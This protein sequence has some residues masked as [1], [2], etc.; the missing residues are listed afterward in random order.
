MKPFTVFFG[1]ACMVA[2]FTPWVHSQDSVLLTEFMAVN[3]TS[4]QDNDGDYSDWIEIYNGGPGPVSLEGYRLTDDPADFGKWRFPA[5]NLVSHGY[6]LVFASGKDRRLPGQALH[7]NFKLDRNGEY[8]ALLKPDGVT[9]LTEYSPTF[10]PQQPNTC[11]G[12]AVETLASNLLVAPE[13]AARLFIPTN[14]DLDS[15]WIQTGFDESAWLPVTTA[16]K[17]DT[18]LTPTFDPLPGTDIQALMLSKS[19]T[20]YL[21]IPFERGDLSTLNDLQLTLRYD[22]GVVAYLNGAEVARRNSPAVPTWNSV[23]TIA[24]P[25]PA[26]LLP[27]FINLNSKLSS[28]KPGRNVLALQGLNKTKTD[29]DF[30]LFPELT[31]SRRQVLTSVT[32]FFSV[33]TPAAA[34]SPGLPGEAG[35]PRLSVESGVYTNTLRLSLSV[36]SATSVIRYTLDR[37]EPTLT[38]PLYSQ[39]IEITNSILLKARAFDPGLLPSPITVGTY[40]ILLPDLLNFTSDLPIVLVDN[41]GGKLVPEAPQ[42]AAIAIYEPVLGRSSILNAPDTFTRATLKDRGS[43]TAGQPK[44]NLAV[45]TIEDETRARDIAPFGMPQ[46]SDWILYAPLEWDRALF[47]NPFIYQLSNEMGRY[48]PR[49]RMVEVY[50]NGSGAV[51]K[52][53]YNGVYVWMEKVKQGPNRVDIAALEPND[54]KA[55]EVTGGYIFKIDRPDPADVGFS[56]G[57]QELK[58]VYPKEQDLKQT[59]RAPQ[60]AYLKSYLNSFA[61]ALPTTSFPGKPGNYAQYLDVDATIDFHILNLLS[62]NVDALVLST[63]LHKERN[64]PFTFGPVWDF[65]RSMGSYDGRDDDPLSWNSTVPDLFATTWFGR[66]FYD[67]DFFQRWVDRWQEL[68]RAQ[69]SDKHML[70]LIASFESELTEAQAR[71]FA[72]WSGFP[73]AGGHAGEVNIMRQW[74]LAR[75]AWVDKNFVPMPTLARPSGRISAGTE[76]EIVA[77][78]GTIFYTLD[79]TDPRLSGGKTNPNAV[80]YSGPIRLTQNSR[81]VARAKFNSLSWKNP[82]PAARLTNEW[83][84]AASATYVVSTPPIVVT[85]IMYHP[86]PPPP[87]SPYAVDDFEFVELKNIGDQPY[88][89]AG[90][91]FTDGI[92][93]TFTAASG[94]RL[95]AGQSMVLAKNV[96]AFRSRYGIQAKVAGPFLG[97]LSDA[98]ERL[99]LVGPYHEPILD[100]HYDNDW[101]MLTEGFGFSLTIVNGHAPL[102]SWSRPSSWRGSSQAG[103]SPGT[104]DPPTHL[105]H[106]R[107]NEVVALTDSV[108]GD[109]IELHNPTEA[110]VNLEGWYLTDDAKLPFKF[111]IP[112]GSILPAK[113]YLVFTEKQFGLGAKGFLLS[114]RG[115]D[116]WL[117]AADLAGHLLG[118]VHGFAF[119]ASDANTSFGRHVTTAGEEFFVAQSTPTMGR[120]NAGPKVGPVVIRELMYH[121]PD[122]FVN[123]AFWNNRADEYIELQNIT[124]NEVSLFDA[125]SGEPWGLRGSVHFD[126]GAPIHLPANEALILVGFDPGTRPAQ[127]TDFRSRFNLPESVRVLGPFSGNLE[128]SAGEVRLAKPGPT[129]PLTGE[130]S[131]VV[132]DQVDYKDQSPWPSAADGGGASLRRI[133]KASFGNDAANWF[134]A[135]PSPGT[136]RA[137]GVPPVISQPPQSK[138]ITRGHPAILSGQAEGMGP[139]VYQWRRDDSPVPG[140]TNTILTLDAVEDSDAGAYTLVV[141]NRNGSAESTPAFL[142]VLQPATI[143]VHPESKNLRPGTNATLL[144]VAIGI[145]KLSYQWTLNARPIL[146]ATGNVLNLIDAKLSDAGIYRVKVTDSIGSTVSDA[147]TINVLIRPTFLSQPSSL[148]ALLGDTVELGVEVDGLKPSGYRWRRNNQII[149]PAINSTATNRILRVSNVQF[150]SAGTYAV[151][152]TNLATG[153]SGT[154]SATAELIV[155]SDFDRDRLG[156]AWEAQF[157]YSTNNPF[158]AGFD[159]DGD[160]RDNLAEFL[161]GTDPKDKESY[162]RIESIQMTGQGPAVG[163]TARTN[164]GYTVQFREGVARGRWQ[165][166]SQVPA[167]TADRPVIVLDRFPQTAARLYRIATPQILG[168]LGTG[169]VILSSPASQTVVEGNSVHLEVIAIGEGELSYQWTKDHHDLP[170]ETRATLRMDRVSKTAAGSYIVR[171]RDANGTV[172]SEPALLV[173]LEKPVIP[174][175]P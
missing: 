150:A 132:V 143:V 10:P 57:G 173:I 8:L 61:A 20:A 65:D 148:V 11:F 105:P 96:E 66:L 28:I 3:E 6:L 163:F 17:F 141:I 42:Q 175:H 46:E 24:R 89:L 30:L 48:A 22:D 130:V 68:R 117:F 32:R 119:G 90:A 12:L 124:G 114:S 159:D 31:A 113:G 52:V 75:T 109:S 100:F 85:E 69:L 29:P 160:G 99:V 27:E 112:T 103:G 120:S 151:Q 33:P 127:L 146:G 97:S 9:V 154:N 56:A 168:Q 129:D 47:R 171:V 138:A 86:A 125:L 106:I 134:A 165:L 23:A 13:A 35:P 87:G 14:G 44:Q 53:D 92:T 156:D 98:G 93:F 164:H 76:L 84:G 43:S 40:L 39:P 131:N 77:P 111:R 169:P 147:A 172:T 49:T 1:L 73:P 83:S 136:D 122:V 45:E 110:D 166:L 123:R 36:T 64:A 155:M 25:N 107:V 5:T 135:L 88:T 54:T 149:S 80:V 118:Y 145:G 115:D 58:W 78:Q 167:P 72:K 133:E 108:D 81:V 95:E 70:A 16:I 162:L 158:N 71:N 79:G 128:N 18:G 63:F 91:R 140:A 142:K 102:E 26:A 2:A 67:F 74:L 170:N 50:F 37:K 157:G 153:T 101:E 19:S 34:N 7:A 38:S 4:L 121:P 139:L 144:V 55:P 126:F 51:G 21:R 174:E 15:D 116:V 41:F 161:A 137:P 60:S 82:Y 104:D 59:E 152:V 62:L 94:N